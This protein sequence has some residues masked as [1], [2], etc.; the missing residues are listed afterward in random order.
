MIRAIMDIIAIVVVGILMLP[1]AL[2][3]LS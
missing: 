3:G 1:F 2:L